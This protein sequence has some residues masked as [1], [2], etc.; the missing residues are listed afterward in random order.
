MAVVT[1]A[2]QEGAWGEEVGAK[3][4]ARLSAR[5]LDRELLELASAHSGVPIE[6]LDAMDERGRSLW[7]H[8]T[9]LWRTVPVPLPDAEHLGHAEAETRYPPTGP[10]DTHALDVLPTAYWAAEHYQQLIAETIRMLA[11]EAGEE[12][13]VIVGRGGQCALGRAAGTVHA[14]LVAPFDIRADRVRESTGEERR[15]VTIRLRRG[16][17]DREAFHSQ[18]GDVNWMDPTLYDYVISTERIS[19]DLAA[20]LLSAAAHAAQPYR[21]D[22]ALA[23]AAG[24]AGH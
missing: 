1:I 16:D 4:A 22:A 15:S 10:V 11:A 6:V 20:D 5:L 19:T 12:H 18:A 9:D 24:H 8:P 13:V 3:L 7:R 23:P 2:R 14:L 21:P 17:R